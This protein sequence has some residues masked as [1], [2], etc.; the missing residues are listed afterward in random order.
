MYL[1]KDE[2]SLYVTNSVD[3]RTLADFQHFIQRLLTEE[4]EALYLER[5]VSA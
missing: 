5:W 2:I 3:P 1:E 4:S